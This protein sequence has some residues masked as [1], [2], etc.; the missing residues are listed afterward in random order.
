MHL[1]I[2]T[3]E[4]ATLWA[5][6]TSLLFLWAGLIEVKDTY[7]IARSI[8]QAQTNER[9]LYDIKEHFKIEPIT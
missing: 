3:A 4:R 7:E 9:P 5:L 6:G 8:L 2:I 1:Q